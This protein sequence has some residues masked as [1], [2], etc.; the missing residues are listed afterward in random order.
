MGIFSKDKELF[1]VEYKD[2][3]YIHSSNYYTDKNKKSFNKK[4]VQEEISLEDN[5]NKRCN[6]N[7]LH[8]LWI[9]NFILLVLLPIVF[10]IIITIN[11]IDID[12]IMMLILLGIFSALYIYIL[13]KNMI[14]KDKIVNVYIDRK[15]RFYKILFKNISEKFNILLEDS[16]KINEY[17]NQFHKRYTMNTALKEITGIIVFFVLLIVF[18]YLGAGFYST[19]EYHDSDLMA[20][21]LILLTLI[22]S[23]VF[24]VLYK[25]FFINP[26]KRKNEIWYEISL[27]EEEITAAFQ[28]LVPDNN[29]NKKKIN[30][31]V[32]IT[33]KQPFALYFMVSI[34]TGFFFLVWDY[35]MIMA[36]QKY[37][38]KAYLVEDY[39][40]ELV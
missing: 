18:L 33:L 19:F 26:L 31:P 28:N 23:I 6:I 3:Y 24:I 7:N 29:Q 40:A 8:T 20:V 11:I 12:E 22:I 30:Y 17:I 32:D 38:S 10:L 39:F 34:F 36:K 21:S 13:L 25:I 37:L 35:Q 9:K 16:N 15:T 14:M 1:K 27:F 2:K 5:I 4:T